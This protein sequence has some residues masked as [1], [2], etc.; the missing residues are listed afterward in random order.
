MAGNP[1]TQPLIQLPSSGLKKQIMVHM[2]GYLHQ[3]GRSGYI[4]GSW[5]NPDLYDCENEQGDECFISLPLSPMRTDF[6]VRSVLFL[7]LILANRRIL[8]YAHGKLNYNII[9]L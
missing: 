9:L 8:Q 5:P 4:C 2:L 6:W 1:A 3:P 7:I